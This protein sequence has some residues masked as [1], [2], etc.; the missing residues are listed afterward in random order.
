MGRV[1]ASSGQDLN[2]GQLPVLYF[3]P[4]RNPSLDLG[5]REARLIV[6]LLKSQGLRDRGE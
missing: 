1:S 4:T 6:E 3:S 5:G 2:D